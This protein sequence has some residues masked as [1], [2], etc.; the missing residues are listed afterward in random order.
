MF[1]PLYYKMFKCKREY[2]NAS[3]FCPFFHSEEEKKHWDNAFSQFIKKDRVSYVKDKQKYFDRPRNQHHNGGG[4]F[5]NHHHNHHGHHHDNSNV[6]KNRKRSGN[7]LTS[8]SS[9]GY[10]H[11]ETSPK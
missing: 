3:A 5:H 10:H 4:H 8:G 1:H 2:C 9:N 7:N 11:Q 6:N